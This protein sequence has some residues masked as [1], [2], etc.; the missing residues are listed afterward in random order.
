MYFWEQNPYLFLSVPESRGL[1]TMRRSRE[2]ILGFRI[3]FS[4]EVKISERLTAKTEEHVHAVTGI[5]HLG[6]SLVPQLTS[7]MSSISELH[8]PN[9]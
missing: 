8:F 4:L 9:L 7:C 1:L 2:C 5:G 6:L 3:R